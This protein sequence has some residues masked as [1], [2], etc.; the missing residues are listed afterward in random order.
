M[1]KII[2]SWKAKF[3]LDT[4]FIIIY[5]MLNLFFPALQLTCLQACLFMRSFHYR[6]SYI[7]WPSQSECWKSRFNMIS[8]SQTFYSQEI[9]A[10][11]GFRITYFLQ[12]SA[13]ALISWLRSCKKLTFAKIEIY[14]RR[15]DFKIQCPFLWVCI[16]KWLKTKTETK[17]LIFF[18][19]IFIAIRIKKR[20]PYQCLS[21]W[22]DRHHLA[23]FPGN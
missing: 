9:L 2:H 19:L 6:T 1:N 16:S 8:I 23:N 22:T 5:Y 11:K 18:V 12:F 15:N 3:S 7:S 21:C 20:Q 14:T 10:L 4:N 17:I 13:L